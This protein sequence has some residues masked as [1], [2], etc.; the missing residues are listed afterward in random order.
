MTNAALPRRGEHILRGGPS[1]TLKARLRIGLENARRS[2]SAKKT[3]PSLTIQLGRA[4]HV[5]LEHLGHV[6][7]AGLAAHVVHVRVLNFVTW[8][9]RS[10]PA[11][12]TT[13]CSTAKM[14]SHALLG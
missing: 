5:R 3:H 10:R 6:T 13:A 12:A 2:E 1:A 14:E 11:H 8:P 4:R 7:M 9:P